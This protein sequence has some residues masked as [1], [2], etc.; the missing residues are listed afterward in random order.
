MVLRKSYNIGN[1]YHLQ[2]CVLCSPS[3][4]TYSLPHV[5]TFS[6]VMSLS[7]Y[8]QPVGQSVHEANGREGEETRE[9]LITEACVLQ[10]HWQ[11][12]AYPVWRM[13]PSAPELS[14]WRCH[15]SSLVANTLV[16]TQNTQIPWV[17][18]GASCLQMSAGMLVSSLGISLSPHSAHLA[19]FGW[20]ALIPRTV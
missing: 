20:L 13:E 14:S 7:V 8:S 5:L 10:L 15:Q 11:Q 4:S 17:C 18:F 19:C 9:S 3:F 2:I 6:D 12:L 1:F 16:K